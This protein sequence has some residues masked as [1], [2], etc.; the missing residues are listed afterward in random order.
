VAASSESLDE[1][2]QVPEHINRRQDDD[3]QIRPDEKPE[4][5]LKPRNAPPSAFL[6]FLHCEKIFAQF[7]EKSRRDF[8]FLLSPPNKM[9]L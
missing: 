1:T 8:I 2:V 7:F 6:N 4:M 5:S 3:N 9:G